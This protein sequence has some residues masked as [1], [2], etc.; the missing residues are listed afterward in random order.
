MADIYIHY[1]FTKRQVTHIAGEIYF[2]A[3]VIFLDLNYP[4]NP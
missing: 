1:T 2:L 3:V 4:R